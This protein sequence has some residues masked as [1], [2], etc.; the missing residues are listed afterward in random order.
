M[1]QERPVL[2]V[3]ADGKTT[4][5]TLTAEEKREQYQEKRARIARVLERGYVVDR[6]T[7][8]NL[9]PEYHGEWVPDDP[10]EIERKKALGFWIDREYAPKRS[11]H[12]QADEADKARIGDC[13]YMICTKEDKQLIDEIRYEQYVKTH[14][15]PEELKRLKQQEERDFAKLTEQIGLPVVDESAES[16]ARKEDLIAALAK[17][18]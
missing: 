8:D 18:K 5:E 4:T 15:S 10:M 14:G 3:A 7:V 11:L 16:S 12:G 1:S 17:D 9:P 6:A 2:K 13:I